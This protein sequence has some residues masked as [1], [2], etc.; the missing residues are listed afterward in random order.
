MSNPVSR[1]ARKYR[2][3]YQEEVNHPPLPSNWPILAIGSAV[4]VGVFAL[5]NIFFGGSDHVPRAPVVAIETP[6]STSSTQPTSPGSSTTLPSP[7]PAAL[8]PDTLARAA[9]LAVFTTDWSQIPLSPTADIESVGPYPDT[10]ILGVQELMGSELP[11][12]HV[13]HVDVDV[14][15]PGP[16]AP[17]VVEIHITAGVVVYANALGV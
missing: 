14:D 2:D 7:A 12:D 10:V 15:G 16:A 8:D 17:L 13:F 6:G 5:T 3:G 4:L 9:A 1:W 11:A